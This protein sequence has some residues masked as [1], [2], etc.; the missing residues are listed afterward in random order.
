MK[1]K[2]QKRFL[3]VELAMEGWGTSSK[4]I[5]AEIVASDYLKEQYHA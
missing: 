5:N 4:N 3:F 2:K 1:R